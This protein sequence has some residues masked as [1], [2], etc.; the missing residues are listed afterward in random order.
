MF[1]GSMK[2]AH[3]KGAEAQEAKMMI[4]YGALKSIAEKRLRSNTQCKHGSLAKVQY[5]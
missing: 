4:E 1:H 3:C 5:M 2:E